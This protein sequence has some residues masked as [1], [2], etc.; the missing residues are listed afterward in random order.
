MSCQIEGSQRI[1]LLGKKPSEKAKNFILTL[2]AIIC[3][4]E[5]VEV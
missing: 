3:T 1:K 5:L 4:D 2:M